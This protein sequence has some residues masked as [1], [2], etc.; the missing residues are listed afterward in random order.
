MK[1]S[2]KEFTKVLLFGLPTFFVGIIYL[3]GFYP[4][5]MTAD[6]L[7][8]WDQMNTFQLSDWHPVMHTLFNYL[9]T[10]IWYSPAAI[11]LV[12]IIMI[13]LTF[14]YAMSTFYRL[15]V[16]KKILISLSILFSIFPPTGLMSICLWKDIPY[17]AMISLMTILLLDLHYRGS[18]L[19]TN[20]L[21]IIT[22]ILCSFG[23]LFFRHNGLIPFIATYIGLLIVYRNEAKRLFILF[24]SI[25]IVFSIV[26]GP[27]F[28]MLNV[29]PTQKSE[30]FGVLVNGIGAVVKD[31]GNITEEQKGQLNKILPYELWGKDYY[32]YSTNSIKFD[33]Q[34]NSSIISNNPSEFVK[35]SFEIFKQNPGIFIKSYFRQISLIWET[36]QSGD[37]Y[38]FIW[39]YPINQNKYNLL[40]APKS[41]R[42]SDYLFNF[43]DYTGKHPSIFWRPAIFMYLTFAIFIYEFIKLN[44]KI[45]LVS[46]PLFFNIASLLIS[47]PAQDYRYL[48]SNVIIFFGIL[49]MILVSNKRLKI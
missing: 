37:N 21:F 42:I 23:V 47:M 3:L 35:L 39:E 31:N 34:F 4:G 24:T 6:S 30:A 29:Q 22:L 12:Q 14:G 20:S 44:K 28:S 40:N 9:I 15:G 7:A 27:I 46:V 32:A 25:L 8:Q 36:R 33:K 5:V 11:V 19:L 17:S 16:N 13:S 41:N 48:F 18:T 49:P 1:S 45:I 2:I 10:R 26:K 38:V 43:M